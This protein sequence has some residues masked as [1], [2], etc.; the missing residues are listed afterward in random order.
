M[1]WCVS[2]YIFTRSLYFHSPYKI[3]TFCENKQ[4]YYT[5]KVWILFLFFSLSLSFKDF[6]SREIPQTR[7]FL[8]T[9]WWPPHSCFIDCLIKTKISSFSLPREANRPRGAAT[10]PTPHLPRHLARLNEPLSPWVHPTPHR[11]H[12][13]LLLWHTLYP[14]K[15]QLRLCRQQTPLQLQ[16]V[17]EG[18]QILRQDQ[19]Q[20]ISHFRHHCLS[21]GPQLLVASGSMLPLENLHLPPTMVQPLPPENR[22]V[23]LTPSRPLAKARQAVLAHWRVVVMGV[24]LWHRNK[25]RSWYPRDPLR[26]SPLLPK[27]STSKWRGL[28]W[29]QA[30]ISQHLQDFQTRAPRR[31]LY[32]QPLG[33]FE[34]LCQISSLWFLGPQK[35]PQSWPLW[36][37]NQMQAWVCR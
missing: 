18:E 21:Q 7:C 33:P 16:C 35:A 37:V 8:S 4:Q 36:H 27:R 5:P 31:S 10:A 34:E 11:Q 12:H 6:N 17:W 28:I 9:G 29:L 32:A 26:H 30:W 19:Q 13:L 14:F 23:A 20:A 2:L 25:S 1:F 22:E 15:A 3:G 24:T